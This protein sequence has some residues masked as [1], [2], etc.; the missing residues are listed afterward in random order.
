MSSAP[1]PYSKVFVSVFAALT[2]YACGGSSSSSNP[3]LSVTPPPPPPPPDATI[4]VR[5]ATLNGSQEEPSNVT[6]IATGKGAVVV[7]R[8]THEI[9]GG[10]TFTG[11]TAT[12]AGVYM[13][14][15]GG[16]AAASIIDL[17]LQ[18]TDTAVIPPG[19]I[20]SD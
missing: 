17:T 20:L 2:L 13:A 14:N 19:R 18:G 12:S 3:A 11:L 7:D 15:P 16:N 6:T 4:D 5:T 10:I 1:Y 9:T 8:S